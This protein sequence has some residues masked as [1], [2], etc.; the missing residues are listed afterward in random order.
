[1][2]SEARKDMQGLKLNRPTN[3]TI[4]RATW[5]EEKKNYLVSLLIEN[6]KTNNSYKRSFHKE[7]WD[8]IT[9]EMKK[10]FPESYFTTNQLKQLER[11]LRK[12]YK[13]VKCIILF[14]PGFEWN[15]ANCMLAASNA[16]WQELLER[17]PKAIRWHR[18]IIP[19]FRALDTLY[20]GDYVGVRQAASKNS[21]S[22]PVQR[23]SSLRINSSFVPT[24][25]TEEMNMN[26]HGMLPA[27][28]PNHNFSVEDFLNFD[29]EGDPNSSNLPPIPSEDW[30]IDYQKS[31]LPPPVLNEDLRIDSQRVQYRN[32][33]RNRV[34]ACSD[35]TI[36]RCMAHS[37]YTIPRCIA[38]YMRLVSNRADLYV[39]G[40]IFKD[41]QNREIFLSFPD[42]EKKKWLGDCITE[43]RKKATGK[44]SKVSEI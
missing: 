9:M 6:T 34:T 3:S 14:Q 33:K 8:R 16:H 13:S 28:D 35:Y 27:N 12:L 19:H 10:R 23:K 21:G 38:E 4:K 7:K 40:E 42:L 39:V 30:R 5:D 37:D 41:K 1:M 15:H 36:Q 29:N 20:G 11:D 25:P 17:D 26:P 24:G 18:K 2:G 32:G 44:K 31:N 43:R 22:V